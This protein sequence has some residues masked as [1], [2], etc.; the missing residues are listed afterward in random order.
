[1]AGI[2]V[3]TFYLL[4]L[5]ARHFLATKKLE[6]EIYNLKRDNKTLEER[7]NMLMHT[8]MMHEQAAKQATEKT[9]ETKSE[10]PAG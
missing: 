7:V 1:L 9:T 5:K 3:A 4:M 10:A 8:Q 2:L 6:D